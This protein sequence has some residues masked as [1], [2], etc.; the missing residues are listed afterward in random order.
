MNSS[1]TE[2]AML[3]I[4]FIILLVL[5]AAVVVV[6]AYMIFHQS[7]AQQV[8]AVPSGKCTCEDIPDLRNRL[9][10]VNAA[11]TEYQAAIGDV[12]AHDAG[13][14]SPTMYN[15][16]TFND[17]KANV[18]NAINGAHTKGTRSGSG[19]TGTDCGTT[20]KAPTACLQGSFQTH[21]N[22]HA[23]TCQRTRDQLK[24]QGKGSWTTNYKDSMTMIEYWNDEI[25]GYRAEIPYL[26]AE[27]A[28]AQ[29]KGGCTQ[30][31]C[32][33]GSGKFYNDKLECTNNCVRKIATLDNW[34]W[35][36]NPKDSTY[37]GKKY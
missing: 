33:K 5:L 16:G 6:G 34:C 23:T 11:I 12:Q 1:H 21:E 37:T 29:A 22:V 27:I 30:Y 3:A 8:V 10:E 19:D 36:Y 4:P 20:V 13:V 2:D 28:G 17:E 24:S 9:N 32:K 25:A 7:G 26:N 15:E 35:E 14:G 31:E 18:Q